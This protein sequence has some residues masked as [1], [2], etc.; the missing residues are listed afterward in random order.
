MNNAELISEARQMCRGRALKGT[1]WSEV[2]TGLADAL[3]ARETGGEDWF[4]GP[5]VHKDACALSVCFNRSANLGD[6]QHFRINEWLK[7]LIASAPDKS[8]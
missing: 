8:T 6:N 7:K 4:P 2:I 3:Q 1:N 5:L